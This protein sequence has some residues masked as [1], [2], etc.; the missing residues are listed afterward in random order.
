[1]RSPGGQS[2]AMEMQRTLDIRVPTTEKH[3]KE[4]LRF[5]AMKM[6]GELLQLVK[7]TEN[8]HIHRISFFKQ[9]CC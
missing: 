6:Y 3:E 2:R 5:R 8:R 1:M 9:I 7:I 4:G